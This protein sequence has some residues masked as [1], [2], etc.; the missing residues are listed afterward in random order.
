MMMQI[1]GGGFGA[2]ALVFIVLK[3]CHVITWP[4]I[5]VLCPIWIS[6]IGA[7]LMLGIVGVVFLALYVCGAL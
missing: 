5:W 4:W 7:V 2:I 6:I 1:S 3:L